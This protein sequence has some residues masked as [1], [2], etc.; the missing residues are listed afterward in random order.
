M[1]ERPKLLHLLLIGLGLSLLAAGA[2]YYT[3]ASDPVSGVYDREAK[4]LA[5]IRDAEAV[6]AGK[7]FL[8]Y[9][10]NAQMGS[11][12]DCTKVFPVHRVITDT[13]NDSP[14]LEL[15]KGPTDEEAKL[16]Y[17][18]S[19]PAGVKLQ[20]V[21]SRKLAGGTQLLIDFSAEMHKAAGACRVTSIRAQI[22]QTATHVQPDPPVSVII[23]VGGQVETALQP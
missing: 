4:N 19:I 11:D 12:Q 6:P 1:T 10:S 7:D 23:S 9:F 22:E 15:L 18:T 5:D 8:L 20:S 13:V 3:S 17:A 14:Y 21:T 16:G 2:M